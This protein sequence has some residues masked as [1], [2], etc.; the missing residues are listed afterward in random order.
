MADLRLPRINKVS[1]SGRITHEIDLKY[2]PKGTPVVR[3][4]LAVD[5]AYKDDTGNWQNS[6]SFI[7]VVAWSKWAESL[8]NNAHKGSAVMVDG[9]IEAR[10]YVDSNGNN[11][12]A[13]EVVADYIQFLEF[14]AKGDE[15]SSSG[16]DVPLP[17]EHVAD[18]QVTNDDVP[19]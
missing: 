17:E 8:S 16:D 19:F 4:A 1:L 7:D 13:V 9:R 3:F 14:R 5:R 10:T 18:A 15:N 6:T 11:R 2:T 12:K